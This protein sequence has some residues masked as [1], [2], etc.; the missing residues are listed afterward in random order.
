MI[1]ET[2]IH[3]MFRRR[4]DL[5]V[6]MFSEFKKNGLPSLAASGTI[7]ANIIN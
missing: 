7:L 6:R 3:W 4:I 1:V 2:R 5:D